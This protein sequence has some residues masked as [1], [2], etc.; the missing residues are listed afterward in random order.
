M[1]KK[2]LLVVHEIILKHS[3]EKR[4]RRDLY[5]LNHQIKLRKSITYW[6]TLGLNYLNKPLLGGD[7]LR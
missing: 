4:K 7:W 1:L 5:F 6:L 2:L 3:T